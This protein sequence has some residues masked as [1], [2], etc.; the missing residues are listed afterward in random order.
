MS[1]PT[2]DEEASVGPAER[3]S[4]SPGEKTTLQTDEEKVE[5]IGGER[6]STL[7]R[8]CQKIEALIRQKCEPKRRLMSGNMRQLVQDRFDDVMNI[9]REI[10]LEYELLSSRQKEK[11]EQEEEENLRSKLTTLEKGQQKLIREVEAIGRISRT[12]DSQPKPQRKERRRKTT[13]EQPEK[14][15]TEKLSYAQAARKTTPKRRTET[16]KVSI[17]E[18]GK[19]KNG[20]EV[21][22]KLDSIWGTA[23]QHWMK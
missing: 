6:V 17:Q 21:C 3:R 22:R 7:F 1:L 23:E 16:L 11:P 4:K 12:D 2:P 19:T 13:K 18:E 9:V 8:K 10:V 15:T 20:D 14:S 5:T